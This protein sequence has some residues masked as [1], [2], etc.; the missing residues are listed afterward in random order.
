M[1][2]T[3]TSGDPM[4]VNQVIAAYVTLRD[5]KE[6]LKKK[7]AEEMAPLS[8][9]MTKLEAWLQNHLNKQNLKTLRGEAGTAFIKE[10]TSATVEDGEAF[11][12]FVKSTE[13]WELI[14]RRCSKSVVD[15]YF[16]TFGTLPPGIKYT[17]EEVCQVR[18]K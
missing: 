10:V 2:L 16:Q 3:T 8:E 11:F 12:E 13:K 4:D 14:D 5:K 9:R 1:V 17:R 7:Q 6:A 18:R 15:A